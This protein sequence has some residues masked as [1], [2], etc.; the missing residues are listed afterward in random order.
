[1]TRMENITQ[2]HT[3]SNEKTVRFYVSVQYGSDSFCGSGDMPFETLNMARDAARALLQANVDAKRIE[4]HVREGEYFINGFTLTPEDSGSENCK[5]SWIADGK[6]TLN[7][8]II[9]KKSDFLPLPDCMRDRFGENADKILYADLCRYGIGLQDYGDISSIGRFSSAKF[10]NG[11]TIG[12]NAELFWNNDR[13]RL[14]RYPNEG[15]LTL[16]RVLDRGKLGNTEK[17]P[18][19]LIDSDT[20][21]RIKKWRRPEKAWIYGYFNYD[22]ANDSSPIKSVDPE[23]C[24]VSP[25]FVPSQ[26]VRGS[27]TDTNEA[28]GRVKGA[29]YYFYNIP[30]ELDA[31]GEYYIDREN[32]L[33]YLIP[34]DSDDDPEICLSL[35]ES[36][37]IR[38]EG[39][40]NLVFDG[41]TLKCT[42]ANGIDIK[43]NSN[44]FRNL[45][46]LDVYGA[47]IKIEGKDNLIESC[48]VTKT[49]KD[50]IFI[51]GGDRVT[52]EAGNNKII[53]CKITYFG[54]IEETYCSGIRINGVGNT[55]SHNEIANCP[56]FAI[57]YFG[58]DHVFEYNYIHDVTLQSTDAGAIY[59]GMD[60]SQQGTVFR[61]N[62]IENVGTRRFRA[63]GIYFDDALS[64]QTAYR[65]VLINVKGCAFLAGGGMDVT[66]RDNLIIN[67][68][69]GIFFDDRMRA[70]LTGRV[71]SSGAAKDQ[72]MWEMLAKVPY[73]TSRK[74]INKYPLLAKITD[75]F[76]DINS[77]D[78]PANPLRASVVGNSVIGCDVD[79]NIADSVYVYGH[80]E[81]NEFSKATMPLSQSVS[82]L[83]GNDPLSSEIRALAKK[84]H[85]DLDKIGIENE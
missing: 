11:L 27:E 26:G 53:N 80:V 29:Q 72:C 14:A 75:S 9:L 23:N 58:N 66:I 54:Q 81:D 5:I 44:V 25:L 24:T 51:D 34:S 64:G 13:M 35:S 61:Y 42:R 30:E 48:V 41:F 36:P 32:N 33:L 78:F 73:R 83:S 46:V 59:G 43:G 40:S 28:Y 37:I 60:W 16:P 3:E 45:L 63:N 67:C 4:I 84:H 85:I 62:L 39:V 1:M 20:N 6:V 65:N 79:T 69:T 50:G 21:E 82:C 38:G 8:G 49:G 2:L 18:V 77:R 7:G 74:W 31:P 15:F 56:H 22:W 71:G 68:G 52:L 76:E 17:S 55:V 12:T 70:G 19:Y 47:G 57:Y 10:Y